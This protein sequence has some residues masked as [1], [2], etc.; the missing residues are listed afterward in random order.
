MAWYVW[1]LFFWALGF[2]TLI[3]P[4]VV[5]LLV[6][7]GIA[8]GFGYSRTSVIEGVLAALLWPVVLVALAVGF[9][10]ARRESA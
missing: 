3:G 1:V 5:L 9:V 6:G 7:N 4:F 10:K 2:V 8:D